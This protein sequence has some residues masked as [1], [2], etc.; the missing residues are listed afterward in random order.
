MAKTGGLYRDEQKLQERLKNLIGQ[1]AVRFTSGRL[2]KKILAEEHSDWGVKLQ[3]K[4]GSA[5]ITLLIDTLKLNVRLPDGE[6]QTVPAILHD[7]QY[8][9]KYSVRGSD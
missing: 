8:I 4:I 1:E 9:A 5:L 2:M 3:A 7:R 6:V